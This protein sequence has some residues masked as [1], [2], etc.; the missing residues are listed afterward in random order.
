MRLF[1]QVLA[2]TGLRVS[3]IVALQWRDLELDVPKPY[4]RVRRTIVK[5]R[6]HAPKSRHGRRDVPITRVLSVDLDALHRATEWP[7][8]TDPVFASQA[9]TPLLDRNVRRRY[10]DPVMAEIGAEWAGFHAFRHTYASLLIRSGASAV[11][12]QRRLGHHSAAFTLTT[13]VHLFPDD[14]APALDLALEL[15]A[16]SPVLGSGRSALRVQPKPDNR[17]DAAERPLFGRVV[18]G[19]EEDHV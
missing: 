6:E 17:A 13:Y 9:G 2:G 8:D 16:T 12:L 10:L 14:E 15:A 19:T 11:Q 4:V 7:R 5:G 18:V 1:F 3:E